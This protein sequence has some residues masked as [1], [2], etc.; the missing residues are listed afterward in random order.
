MST[1]IAVDLGN[2]SGRVYKV[3]FDGA[4][5]SGAEVYRF[6]NEPVSVRGVLNWDVLRLWHDIQHGLSAALIEKPEG[7]GVASFGV[8]FGILDKRGVL[9]S[10]PL[11]MRNSREAML[12][13]VN[14]RIPL[15]EVF[16]RTAIAPHVINTLF[17]LAALQ[18]DAPW[19]LDAAH[20]LLTMPNLISYWLTGEM[21]SEFTHSTTTQCFNPFLMDWDGYL[22]QQCNIRREIFPNI[23]QAGEQIGNYQGVSVYAVASHDT[24]SAV[25]AVPTETE[26]FA[27]ISSG[28]WS[29]LGVET[30]AP[31]INDAAYQAGITSEGGAFGTFRPLKLV[32]GMWLIQQ[33]RATWRAQGGETDYDVLLAQADAAPPFTAL[34]DPNWPEFLAPGDMPSRIAAYC[35][36]TEQ[37]NPDG[38]GAIL[39][40]IME[41]LAL[42]YRYAL[43]QITAAAN[44]QVK[45][46]HVVGGG[47]QNA[48]LCQMT[49][50]AMNRTVYAGPVEATALGNAAAQL[51]G[52]GELRNVAEARAVIRASYPIAEYRP[53]HTEKWDAAYTRYVELLG[54]TANQ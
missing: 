7:I 12:A 32:M 22:L 18:Q 5:F 53:Q 43:E 36:Q 26:D 37:P 42:T 47:A 54:K 24:G 9:I 15:Q 33:C 52:R 17:Q 27:Y 8:D 31:I 40:C 13:W 30:R 16:R 49:A 29:L 34:I 19:Q 14:E 51:I 48:V 3:H 45:A 1:L 35:R 21:V 4:H 10:N 6:A 41:S 46:F 20:T 39:R 11:H 23:V 44:K 25:L 50:D 28:T 2:E 38:S